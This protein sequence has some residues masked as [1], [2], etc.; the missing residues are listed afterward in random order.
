M[1]ATPTVARATKITGGLSN[2]SKMPG[3]GYSLPAKECSLGS[4]LRKR[5]GSTCQGCYAMKGRYAF[6]NV[7]RALYRRLESLADPQWIDAM[8]SLIRRTKVR[9]FRW[10]DSGDLQ[11]LAH[12]EQI[13]EVCRQTPRWKH[14]LPTR[15]YETVKAY[16]A[17]HGSFPRNLAVRLSAH[18]I[19]RPAPDIGD[20]PVSSVHTDPANYADAK[21]CPAPKHGNSCRR[22][23]ACWNPNV[24]HVSYRKH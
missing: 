7:Q 20:L 8:A 3:F 17:K 19:D 2:P 12:L 1:P 5:A 22:C 24:R 9:Y 11:D 18:M 6:P 15:E 13:A 21:I 10:H 23:R 4:L 14:W 16:L